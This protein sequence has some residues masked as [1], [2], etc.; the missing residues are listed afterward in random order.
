MVMS[1]LESPIVC[2][3]LTAVHLALGIAAAAKVGLTFDEPAH[4]SSGYLNLSEGEYRWDPS[5]PPLAKM[6]FAM[7]LWLKDA[8]LPDVN[9]DR[10]KR[11]SFVIEANQWCV[12]GDPEA[13]KCFWPRVMNLFFSTGGV[14]LVWFTLRRGDPVAALAGA[15]WIALDPNILAHA[16]LATT[17]ACMVLLYP[18]AILS[19]WHASQRVTFPRLVLAGCVLGAALAA[20]FSGILAVGA[21]GLLSFGR[22][23]SS[24]PIEWRIFRSGEVRRR[25]HKLA[26]T[27]A[28]LIATGFVSWLVIWSAYRFRYDPAPS[29]TAWIV[30]DRA[31]P[32]LTDDYW[33]FPPQPL[34]PAF[35][36]K[37]VATSFHL[38]PEAYVYGVFA[39]TTRTGSRGAFLLGRHW[40]GGRWY[41]FPTAALIK[42]PVPT[43]AL[44]LI[45]VVMGVRSLRRAVVGKKAVGWYFWP[46]AVGAGIFLASS[47][48]GE[49]NIGIRHLLPVYPLLALLMGPAAASFARRS[50]GAAILAAGLGLWQFAV[51]A[52]TCPDFLSY[53]NVAAGG[54]ENGYYYMVDSNL[55]WGQELPK[56]AEYARTRNLPTI[57]LAYFGAGSPSALG[58]DA[59]QCPLQYRDFELPRA[60]IT[61]GTYV[62]S[63]TYLQGLYNGD[64]PW[65]DKFPKL[66]DNWELFRPLLAR[67]RSR[68][69]K[70]RIGHTL[71]VYEATADDIRWCREALRFST[72]GGKSGRNPALP[73]GAAE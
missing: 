40:T 26:A 31:G 27:A 43:I 62:V 52:R 12:R 55:D 19:F 50:R 2:V 42:T 37:S 60:E 53:F 38:L 63:A 45:A 66:R 58:I 41:F 48:G 56:L 17:D 39:L 67:F 18:A 65:F 4:L 54:A 46:A 13:G 47:L 7:P 35:A 23:V 70:D 28:I 68:P 24:S 51:V 30:N 34:G 1:R 44:F 29:D 20:K 15:G 72:T 61:A 8:P 32:R 36:F 6:W 5:H 3:V 21:I 16:S 33:E 11:R 57:K 49:M 10:L 25:D 64:A 73:V 59:E 69:P 14:V 9:S 22:V 71:F